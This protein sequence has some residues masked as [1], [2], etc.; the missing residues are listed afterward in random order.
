MLTLKFNDLIPNTKAEAELKK[1]I[2]QY[3][4]IMDNVD[5]DISI[6]KRN[7]LSFIK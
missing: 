5:P 3:L 4:R 1:K 7:L 2:Q 6:F